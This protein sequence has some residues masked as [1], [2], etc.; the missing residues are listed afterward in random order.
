MKSLLS[1]SFKITRL[2]Y[3]KYLIA[4]MYRRPT[5][6]ILGILGLY[7]LIMPALVDDGFLLNF[8]KGLYLSMPYAL[9][10]LFYPIIITV[11]AVLQRYRNA[12]LKQEMLYEFDDEGVHI[13]GED[14]KSDLA[15]S[16]I[17]EAKELAGFLI[18][19][20]SKRE[21]YLVKKNVLGADEITYIKDKIAAAK[22]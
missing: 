10:M 1:I 14:F 11:I 15:W 21:G 20:P 8:N 18:L 3:A 13:Q 17:R 6:I 16:H 5:V 2:E 12:F 7:S 19:K 4:Y 22:K 9:A